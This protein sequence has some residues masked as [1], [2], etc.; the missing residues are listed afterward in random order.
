MRS[1]PA[2]AAIDMDRLAGRRYLPQ[3]GEFS[4]AATA[5]GMSN[6][7]LK[8]RLLGT[9]AD[10]SRR[11]AVQEEQACDLMILKTRAGGPRRTSC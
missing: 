8:S 11:T 9:A 7:V 10:D 2:F 3:S 1:V 5:P 4:G 6:F